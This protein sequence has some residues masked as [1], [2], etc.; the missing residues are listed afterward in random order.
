[1]RNHQKAY[2]IRRILIVVT[3]LSLGAC[4]PT[5]EERFSDAETY[6]RDADYQSA[7]IELKNVLQ[8]EPDRLDARRMLADASYILFDIAAAE[9]EYR[10]LLSA[11]GDDADLWVAYGRSLLAQGKAA[12]A[13]ENVAPNL[14]P[15]EE[16]SAAA[17]LAEIYL[18]LGNLSAAAE[19]YEQALAL[20]PNH[21]RAMVGAA[22]V[23][24]RSGD[25]QRAITLMDAALEVH[26]NSP[27]VLRSKG[28]VLGSLRRFNDA[29]DTYALAIAAESGS[30]PFLERYIVR[31]NRIAALIE[32]RQLQQASMDLAMFEKMVTDHPLIAFYRGRIS[33]GEGDYEA[34][35]TE[36]LNY[37]AVVPSDARAQAILGAIKFSQN[38]LGQAEQYLSSAVRADIGGETT[39]LLL[40]ETQLRL[41]QSGDAVE[42]LTA[43]SEGS[44]PSAVTLAMLGR[45]KMGEGDADAAIAYFQQSLNRG[46]GDSDSVNLALASSYIA[47]DRAQEAVD[48]LREMSP[49]TDRNFRRETLLIGAYLQ[50]GDTAA[51]ENVAKALI[52]REPDDA[53][54]HA[55]AGVLF[56]NLGQDRRARAQLNTALGIDP[57]NVGALYAFGMLAI[58]NEDRAE[59]IAR[60][61]Q[62]LDVRAT[63]LPA[64]V[65]LAALLEQSDSLADIRPRLAAAKAAAPNSA[66]LQKLGAR[67]ELLLGDTTAAR[68]SIEAGR[69]AFPNDADFVRLDGIA[70]LQDGDLGKAIASLQEAVRRQPENPS[71]HLDLARAR[72]SNGDFGQAITAVRVYREMRPADVRGLAIE[73]DAQLRSGDPVQAT[74]TVDAFDSANP[75]QPF[76]LMLRGDIAFASGDAPAAIDWYEIYAEDNWSRIVALRLAGAHQATGSGQATGFIERWLEQEPGDSSMRRFYGQ[77]LEANG[78]TGDAVRQYERLEREGRLDAIGLNNLAWQYLQ[79][80]ISGASELAKRAHDL[81]PESGDIA[82][83]WGWIL[84]QEGSSEQALEVLRRAVEQSPDNREIQYHLAV[85][86]LSTGRRSEAQALLEDVLDGG[87]EFPSYREAEALA[88]SL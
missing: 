85:V 26:P 15:F 64:L 21:A 87:M 81:R 84:H 70:R 44:D 23:A 14:E 7:V 83:T 73:V 88:R 63:H 57:E 59:A 18:S 30:T 39:R 2:A 25:L 28:D 82:D 46:G 47:T 45:A 49:A 65:Q 66:Q 11:N 13:L 68:D 32:T 8:A 12:E 50:T 29:A 58:A 6:M 22:V 53:N 9:S 76:V 37:L 43:V 62:V 34:A 72:L 16:S 78:R 17:M 69:Q 10:R 20:E 41:N 36:M 60:F 77:L 75:G 79:Q 48:I 19:R 56:A 4:Q 5:V 74:E 27:F 52:R 33:F 24:G 71:N 55:I 1:M 35:E 54:A 67:T 86:L 31:Q 61:D 38:N 42:V 80:G 40:A 51:A 3:A